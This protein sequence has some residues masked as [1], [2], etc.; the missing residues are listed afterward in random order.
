MDKAA[1]FPKMSEA[2][3]EGLVWFGCARSYTKGTGSHVKGINRFLLVNIC[4]F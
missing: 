4:L 2:V 3:E 1:Q